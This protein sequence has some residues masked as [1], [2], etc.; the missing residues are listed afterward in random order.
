MESSYAIDENLIKFMRDIAKI[1]AISEEKTLEL[2]KRRDDPEVI[3]ILIESNLKFVLHTV[4]K[5]RSVTDPDFLDLVSEGIVGLKL[6]VA[7]F[8]P[9]KGFKFST[10]SFF[11]IRK[12]VLLYLNILKRED[13]HVELDS[14]YYFSE[15]SAHEPLLNEAFQV[16]TAQESLFMRLKYGFV[17]KDKKTSLFLNHFYNEAELVG[18][19]E[20]ILEKMQEKMQKIVPKKN[21][22]RYSRKPSE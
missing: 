4:K 21:W 2:F 1:P 22:P 13:S 20:K 8:T 9:E 16:L 19:E 17:T 7:R 10:Y 14:L 5:Y 12:Y 11:W 6:A 15:G 18:R 3:K